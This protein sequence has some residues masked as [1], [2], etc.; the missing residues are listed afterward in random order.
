MVAI[1][2]NN[3]Y[4]YKLAY[5]LYFLNDKINDNAIYQINF[6]TKLKF[7]GKIIITSMLR[8]SEGNYTIKKIQTNVC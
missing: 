6:N 8:N 7:D 1:K 5:E 4:H 3:L 2:R